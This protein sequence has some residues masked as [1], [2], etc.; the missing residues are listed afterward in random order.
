MKKTILA[1]LFAMMLTF[2]GCMND[3]SS[4]SNSQINELTTLSK[5]SL[6]KTTVNS[7]FE[8]YYLLH[9]PCLA[10]LLND[11]EQNHLEYSTSSNP[12]DKA[13]T[14]V[15]DYLQKNISSEIDREWVAKFYNNFETY[16]Y[17]QDKHYINVINSNYYSETISIVE[18]NEDPKVVRE[19]LLSLIATLESDESVD[20]IEKIALKSGMLIGMESFEYWAINQPKWQ[21]IGNKYFTP[22]ISTNKI[23]NPYAV[24]DIQGAI[25]GA[26]GGAF[27]GAPFAG[28]GAGVGALVGA[29]IGAP[30]SSAVAGAWDHFGF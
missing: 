27:T 30:W 23:K 3:L 16:D 8:N 22:N 25:S 29:M 24:A 4:E 26:I 6:A 18:N 17:T 11:I 10:S 13:H 19:K 12:K 21:D 14:F 1:S 2:T 28:A 7:T 5:S 15:V 9:N 20:E